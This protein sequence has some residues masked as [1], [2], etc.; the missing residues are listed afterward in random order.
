MNDDNYK[1]ISVGEAREILGEE[2]THLSDE[3]I[4]NLIRQFEAL[5]RTHIRTW[6][7]KH[8]ERDYP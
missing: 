1:S 2:G 8:N 6:N 7:L 3:Y 4:E 5:A